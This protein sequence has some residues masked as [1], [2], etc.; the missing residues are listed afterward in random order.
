MISPV[1]ILLVEDN[2]ADAELIRG[3]LEE[4]KVLMDVSTARNG[5]EAMEFLRADGN[6]TRERRPDL[7]LLDLNLPKRGGLDVLTSIK[8]DATLR[9]I[10]VV[11]LTSSDSEADVLNS[12]DLGANCYVTKPVGFGAFREIIHAV[13]SF[14]FSTA[15]LPAGSFG[16]RARSATG[17]KR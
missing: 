9:F 8:A 7:I 14:W 4:S 15:R 3:I 12:Y 13:E 5:V 11:I 6:S 16:D 1:Q 2:P 10:P 17:G